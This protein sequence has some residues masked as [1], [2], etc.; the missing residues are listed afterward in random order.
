ME[1]LLQSGERIPSANGEKS[2]TAEDEH[3]WL[4]LKTDRQRPFKDRAVHPAG[5]G[6]SI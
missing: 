3:I 2:S 6:P 4:T 5:Q 1:L